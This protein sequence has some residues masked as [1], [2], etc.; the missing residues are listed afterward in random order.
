MSRPP[1]LLSILILLLVV[2]GLS[3]LNRACAALALPLLVFLGAEILFP[4]LSPTLEI[5]RVLSAARST[6]GEP[7]V[8]T[9]TARNRGPTAR[10]LHVVDEVP[11]G[12]E[13]VQGSCRWFGTLESGRTAS[14]SYTVRGGRGLHRWEEV[15]L[16]AA[17]TWGARG[18]GGVRHAPSSLM[19]LPVEERIRRIA[20]EPLETQGFAGP[21][22]GRRPGA[23]ITF[24]GVREYRPGDPLRRIN[25]RLSARHPAR[26]FTNEHEQERIADVGIILDAREHSY[27]GDD[28]RR[29]ERV[30]SA[31]MSV[32]GAFLADSNRVSLLVCGA[33]L[34][35]VPGGCGRVQRE[36]IRERLAMARIGFNY[37]LEHFENLPRRML[38]RRSQIVV[39]GPLQA[40]DEQGLGTLRSLGYSLLL[41]CPAPEPCPPGSP[42][43]PEVLGWRL[44]RIERA[45]LLGRLRGI[46][47]AVVDWDPTLPL[48]IALRRDL[49]GGRAI[50]RYRGALL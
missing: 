22:P 26:I 11:G 35:W 16:S 20:I 12:L 4:A 34:G 1:R 9:V 19:V 25:T 46:G 33:N 30:V 38:P 45:L 13:V 6:R 31:A 37:A 47:A 8:V 42:A 49:P 27:V 44:T 24:Y 50:S 40:H 28:G 15:R 23:G 17:G 43:A 2:L 3:F 10:E 5:T 41:I 39:V 36:R 29:F 21:I 32:A 48:G 18:K 14:W 7:V